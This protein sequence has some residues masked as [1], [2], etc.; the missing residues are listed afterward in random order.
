MLAI[1]FD[2]LGGLQSPLDRSNRLSA[3]QPC[4]PSIL[5][6]MKIPSSDDALTDTGWYKFSNKSY[7]LSANLYDWIWKDLSG[8]VYVNY[9]TS[10][11]LWVPACDMLSNLASV[12]SF[13]F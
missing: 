8:I 4:L 9:D 10:Q 2:P 12:F 7:T 5:R 13:W 1:W 11:F 3:C 6:R